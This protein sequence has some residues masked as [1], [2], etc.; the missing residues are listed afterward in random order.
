M[1]TMASLSTAI[2]L[3]GWSAVVEHMVRSCKKLGLKVTGHLP[4]T[5]PCLDRVSALQYARWLIPFAM[6]SAMSET[7][8]RHGRILWKPGQT[9][10]HDCYIC[11]PINDQERV[12]EKIHEDEPGEA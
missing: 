4:N 12:E 8:C 6:L 5:P 9:L 2:R 11:P 10:Q 3:C 1:T 7:H